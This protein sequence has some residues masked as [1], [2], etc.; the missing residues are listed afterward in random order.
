M[1]IWAFFYLTRVKTLIQAEFKLKPT[2]FSRNEF[3]ADFFYDNF[4]EKCFC[5]HMKKLPARKRLM[6]AKWLVLTLLYRRIDLEAWGTWTSALRLEP[7]MPSCEWD[8]PMLYRGK[9]ADTEKWT[10]HS[11]ISNTM[12][13]HNHKQSSY[14]ITAKDTCNKPPM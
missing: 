4:K 2:S 13:N 11:N 10:S 3:A 6:G 8:T 12:G 14:D 1:F 7:A 5:Q 9:R